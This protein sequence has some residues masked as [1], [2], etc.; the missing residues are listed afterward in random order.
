M[1]SHLGRVVYH[2]LEWHHLVERLKL[3]Q[4]S[5]HLMERFRSAVDCSP[6][7]LRDDKLAPSAT[8]RSH[9]NSQVFISSAECGR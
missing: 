1:L 5:M 7:G 3:F 6:S 4:Q 9:F 8:G 2:S